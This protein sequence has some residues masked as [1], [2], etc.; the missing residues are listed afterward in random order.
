MTAAEH[1]LGLAVGALLGALLVLGAEAAV[2]RLRSA[3]RGESNR[4]MCGHYE[5][6]HDPEHG[7]GRPCFYCDGL[8]CLGYTRRPAWHLHHHRFVRR[9]GVNTYY[10]CRCGSRRVS[11]PAHARV[12]MPVDGHWL[13][14][15]QWSTP[16]T[17]APR[18]PAG[19]SK[20]AR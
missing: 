18:G 9:L 7:R 8:P 12:A 1:G 15:G 5:T 14:T 13:R 17:V 2:S 4:C 6:G 3:R 11:W 10:A 20:A 16:P 19:A